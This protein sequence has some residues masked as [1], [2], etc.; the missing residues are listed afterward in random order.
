M[1]SPSPAASPSPAST[2]STTKPKYGTISGTPTSTTKS[3]PL[4]SNANGKIL[5]PGFFSPPREG[6]AGSL[7]EK[8]SIDSIIGAG[9]ANGL[10]GASGNGEV[11]PT[12]LGMGAAGVSGG[13]QNSSPWVISV[14]PRNIKSKKLKK[15]SG[16]RFGSG[17]VTREEDEEESWTIYVSVEGW[18][19]LTL[20]RGER[21]LMRLERDVSAS[22]NRGW[23][24]APTACFGQEGLTRCIYP[25]TR[26][27]SVFRPAIYLPPHPFLQVHSQSQTVCAPFQRSRHHLPHP[28]PGPKSVCRDWNLTDTLQWEDS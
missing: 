28:V 2:M 16:S 21:D 10:T 27:T 24:L 11:T 1:V 14:T 17:K 7:S 18:G 6:G 5:L 9:S 19:N 22:L 12:Q 26:N 3:R 13:V 25:A 4:T 23:E 15:G 8:R 20:G